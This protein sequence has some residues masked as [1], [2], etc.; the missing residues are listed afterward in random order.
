MTVN[1]PAE[2]MSYKQQIHLNQSQ[3]LMTKLRIIRTVKL[4]NLTQG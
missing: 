2:V 1:I 4:S 3:E